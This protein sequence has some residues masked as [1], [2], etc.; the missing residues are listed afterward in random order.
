METVRVVRD[1]SVIE[2]WVVLTPSRDV[3]TGSTQYAMTYHATRS[4]AITY[5]AHVS[6]VGGMA[7]SVDA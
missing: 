1:N 2:R 6:A 3:D 4:D 5:A 7:I